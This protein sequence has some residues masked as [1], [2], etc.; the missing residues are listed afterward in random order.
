LVSK[1]TGRDRT[2]RAE[3]DQ[4]KFGWAPFINSDRLCVCSHLAGQL[5]TTPA[6]LQVSMLSSHWAWIFDEGDNAKRFGSSAVQG[7]GCHAPHLDHQ[8]ACDHTW[9]NR[10]RL[11]LARI[12]TK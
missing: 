8:E 6:D 3:L 10:M 9:R 2:K 4:Q 12:A 11:E 7:A 1:S 5:S